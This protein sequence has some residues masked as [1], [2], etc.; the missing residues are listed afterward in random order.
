MEYKSSF[1]DSNYNYLMHHGV[2]GMKWG[3]R[4][5]QDSSGRLTPIGRLRQNHVE[6]KELKSRIKNARNLNYAKS[7]HTHSKA[8]SNINRQY[9]KAMNSDKM[10]M[11]R[12][13][14]RLAKL[15][16]NNAVDRYLK[17]S[18]RVS[19]NRSDRNASNIR[20]NL[21]AVTLGFSINN[22]D[23]ARKRYSKTLNAYQKEQKRVAAPYI[24]KFKKQAL[25]DLGFKNDAERGRQLMDKHKLWKKYYKINS[26]SNPYS[27]K[28]Y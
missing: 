26:Y 13:E 9:E 1:N 24:E 12:S 8:M 6:R 22:M 10:R 27:Y 20:K 28:E 3:V 19:N 16:Y 18:N 7:G 25:N 4:R 11:L 5:Y 15:D 23:S 14:A 17:S 2:K 21:D